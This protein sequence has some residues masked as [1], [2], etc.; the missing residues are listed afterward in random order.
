M[1]ILM[2]VT[3]FVVAAC[4]TQ[5]DSTTTSSEVA[6]STTTTTIEPRSGLP[7]WNDR[8]FYEIFVRSFKDADGDGIGDFVGLTDSLDYLNDGDPDTADD[9]GITGIWLMPI[10]PSPSY[11]GYDVTDYR[12]V[13]PE[14]GTMEEFEA[15]LEAAH[16]RGI[17]VLI[18][19]VINHSSVEHPW[20]TASAAGDAEYVD[21]YR[22][23]SVDDGA[24]APWGAPAWHPLGDRYYFGLFWEGMPD[25]N[26]EHDAVTAELYDIARYWLEEVGVDG[27]RLDAA[28]HLIED[29]EVVSDTPETRAWLADFNAYVDSIA[30]DALVLGE[31]W[32]PTEVAASYVPQSLDLA[33]EF[34]I[35]ESG[36]EAVVMR[37]AQRL[38]DAV[39]LAQAAYP[40][41]QYAT[42]LTNHDMDRIMSN[43]GGDVTMAKLGATWL[44]TSAG[45]PF[46][47]YGEE[48]G[49]K[50]VKPD[51]RIRTPMPW[52]AEA[53]GLGFT[54]GTTWE[55]QFE[56]YET[57]NVE[58]QT[59]DPGS[60]LSHY[61][62]LIAYRNGSTA[63]R[64]GDLVPVESDTNAV[65][66][67]LR[68]V[69]DDHVLVVL[70]VGPDYAVDVHLDLEEGPL[71][72]YRGV[73]PVV[74]PPARAPDVSA[75]GGLTSYAPVESIPPYGF[76]V[77]EFTEE[78]SP[79]PPPTTTTTSSTLP[80]ATAED[81]A[82]MAEFN[83]L[84][85]QGRMDDALELV[86]PDAVYITSDG[87]EAAV[88]DPLPPEAGVA[89][90]RDWNGDGVV[91]I[92]DL[93]VSGG[94]WGWVTTVDVDVECRADGPFVRCAS[95]VLDAFAISADLQPLDV[96]E[97]YLVDGGRIVEIREQ[98]VVSVGDTWFE[99]W[100]ESMSE[101]ERW[102]AEEH[103]EAYDVAFRG[104]CCGATLQSVRY[105][106]E[107]METHGD[108]IRE[109]LAESD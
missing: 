104:P 82:V 5:S 102:V 83:A 12:T 10:F 89:L 86:A 79:P 107:S 65:T 59:D 87:F 9:L 105:S 41:L 100:I 34:G 25:L 50:G 47:Y 80:G 48:V 44:L 78:P 92:A 68:S 36:G 63:L 6:A 53:P 32:S 20:F 108:L 29:G 17:A 95:T 8:V 76:L 30:P 42:F 16:E 28:R 69:G 72:G 109:W 46:V 77:L 19:L 51:E 43:V 56:G 31:V 54:K 91:T 88:F 66:A 1:A 64:R 23:S 71:R 49:L 2:V 26:L 39:A 57:F 45:V 35:A 101:Y 106:S 81:I 97:L 4:T 7:W 38:A 98:E 90:E 62:A 93:I 58:S 3:A 18:D 103:P 55:S 75:T 14:Y 73:R 13:N 24:T 11:H 21:W 27:F 84:W 15:F 37:D 96:E 61:R 60:L 70:N 40:P 22:W 99:A 94:S 74:G 67:Y 33:F 52:T 85:G